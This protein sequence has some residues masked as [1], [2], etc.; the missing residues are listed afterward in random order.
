MR[1]TFPGLRTLRET[2]EGPAAASAVRPIAANWR[3]RRRTE[4]RFSASPPEVAPASSR[5]I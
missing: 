5:Q 2:R 4:R 1:K 3:R